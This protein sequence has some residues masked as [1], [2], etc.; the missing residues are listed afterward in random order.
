MRFSNI[1]APEKTR[2]TRYMPANP[3]KYRVFAVTRCNATSRVVEKPKAPLG[4]FVTRGVPEKPD[5]AFFRCS[6]TLFK[7]VAF[8]CCLWYN[9]LID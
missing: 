5:F 2:Y 3:C 7:D 9:A 6:K 4:Q 1:K 8:C